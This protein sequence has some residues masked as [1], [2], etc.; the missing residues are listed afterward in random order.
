MPKNGLIGIP[1]KMGAPGAE[2]RGDMQT[3]PVSVIYSMYI[4]KVV[5]KRQYKTCLPPCIHNGTPRFSNHI[6]IPFPCFMV[7]RLTNLK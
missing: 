3:P 6:V 2:G 7:Q 5:F 4:I 1:G